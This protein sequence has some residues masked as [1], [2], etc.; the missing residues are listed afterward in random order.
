MEGDDKEDGGAKQ[1]EE[2]VEAEAEE[3]Q[4][5]DQENNKDEMQD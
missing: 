2:P 1:D 5:S 4:G 3:A